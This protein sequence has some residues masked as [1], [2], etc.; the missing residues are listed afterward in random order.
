M[1]ILIKKIKRPFSKRIPFTTAKFA[2]ILSLGV[3]SAVSHAATIQV[4]S[5]SDV[6]ADC[7]LREAIAS[8]NNGFEIGGCINSVSEGFGVNDTITFL[9][10]LDGSI[11]LVSG[12]LEIEEGTSVIIDASSLR[13]GMT[14]VGN[15]QTR[16]I[17]VRGATL[18][19][20]DMTITEG[21]GGISAFSGASLSLINS[22][23]IGNVANLNGGGIFTSSDT[24]LSLS[25]STISENSAFNGA[26][27]SAFSANS[28]IISNSSIS[29]NTASNTSGGI[30]ISQSTFDTR[31]TVVQLNDSTVSGNIADGNGGG[32]ILVGAGMVY[33]NNS[34]IIDNSTNSEGGGLFVGSSR[35]T[36]T[37]NNSTVSGN[38]A[39]VAGAILSGSATV[40][41]F[42]STVAA[43]SAETEGGG[44]VAENGTI[45]LS[46]SIIAGS[47]NGGDCLLVA[48]GAL[49]ADSSNIIQDGSCDTSALAVDPLLSPLADNGGQTLT[50]ALRSRSPAI[51]AGDLEIC[52]ANS[53]NGLDQ[54]GENRFVGSSCDIGA[55]EYQG[56]GEDSFY[57]IPMLNGKAAIFIL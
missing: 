13:D 25:N 8:I 14:L 1:T 52:T 54:R 28:I 4:T 2:I 37:L 47:L 48:S 11:S 32:G 3:C 49:F 57:V 45:T 26:G 31:P 56:D 27:I 33:L 39:D 20:I 17:T 24:N 53:I 55:F 5:T 10:S 38:S 41:L 22:N 16:V 30:G 12:S 6:A 50:H 40:N 34:S 36:V 43:N 44:I 42:N 7:T 35:A 51:N 23:V 9:P 18:Q 21:N 29:R 19:I 46:N 15:L